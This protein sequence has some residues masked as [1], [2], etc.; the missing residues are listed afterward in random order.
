MVY[1]QCPELED[2]EAIKA[3]LT[4]NGGNVQAV[5]DAEKSRHVYEIVVVNIDNGAEK[6][7]LTF[8]K[9]Q[10]PCGSD[11]ITRLLNLKPLPGGNAAAYNIYRDP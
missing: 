2:L 8:P 10:N 11:I 1:Q 4:V 3:M 7:P 5:I 6:I 9:S